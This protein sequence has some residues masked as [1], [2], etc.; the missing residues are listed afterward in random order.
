MRKTRHF[1][2]AWVVCMSCPTNPIWRE[3]R[4]LDQS[5][6][7][8][9]IKAMKNWACCSHTMENSNL[10]LS[11]SSSRCLRTS[12]SGVGRRKKYLSAS[13]LEA[14]HGQQRRPVLRRP[15]PGHRIHKRSHW[16]D[17]QNRLM[18][19]FRQDQFGRPNRVTFQAR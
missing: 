14:C 19:L 7:V 11:I 1:T 5:N 2:I 4:L 6:W 3:N 10:V 9:P 15:S 12:F 17:L 8:V 18:P 13:M 16:R